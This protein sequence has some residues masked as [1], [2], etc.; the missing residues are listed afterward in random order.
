MTENLNFE[1]NNNPLDEAKYYE[2]Y[3][4]DQIVKLTKSKL[5]LYK[6]ADSLEHA[7]HN[8]ISGESLN[9][10]GAYNPKDSQVVEKVKEI[11]EKEV[12]EKGL[13][14]RKM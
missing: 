11:I 7:I 6:D 12:E 14:W 3:D 2:E 13:D 8:A 4:I 10:S 9:P 5:A 1:K